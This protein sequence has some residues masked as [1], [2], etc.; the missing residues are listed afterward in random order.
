VSDEPF[1]LANRLGLSISEA[2]SVIGVA[3]GSLRS[4]LNEIPHFHVGRR[5][6]IPVEG[7]KAWMMDESQREKSRVDNAASEIL[8]SLE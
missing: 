5:V 6:V 7:L 1:K 8:K 4:V 2:A 3:E